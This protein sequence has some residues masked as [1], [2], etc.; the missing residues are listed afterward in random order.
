MS[1]SKLLRGGW[2]NIFWLTMK[3][4]INYLLIIAQCLRKRNLALRTFKFKNVSIR[5]R[6]LSSKM[7]SHFWAFMD[8]SSFPSK[9]Q[10]EVRTTLHILR[11]KHVYPL[12]KWKDNYMYNPSWV[13]EKSTR[14]ILRMTKAKCALGLIFSLTVELQTTSFTCV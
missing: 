4:I 8:F 13:R 5:K 7:R 6:G 12:W 2:T 9:G 1:V 11:Q 14:F 3:T 10:Q